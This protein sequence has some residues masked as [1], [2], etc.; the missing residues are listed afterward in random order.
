MIAKISTYPKTYYL[1][2]HRWKY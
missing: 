1:L 2:N